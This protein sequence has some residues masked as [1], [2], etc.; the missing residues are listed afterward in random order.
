MYSLS[1]L[2]AVFGPVVFGGLADRY[3]VAVALMIL[4]A[5]TS[6]TLQSSKVLR[7]SVPLADNGIAR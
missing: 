3:G 6:L 2:S 5:L 1:G 7:K 4:A